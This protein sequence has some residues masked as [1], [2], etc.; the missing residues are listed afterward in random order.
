MSD[1]IKILIIDDE[2]AIVDILKRRFERM[3]FLVITAYDGL[4]GIETLRREK[5][6]IVVCDIK[7][8]KGIS[9]VEVLKAAKKYNPSVQFVAISG[10]LISDKLIQSIMKGGASLFIKKPFISLGKVTK[11]IADL[12]EKK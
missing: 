9:G 7:M 2:K 3:N 8:P 10:H 11:Q 12:V 6:D 5:V 4:K 1:V